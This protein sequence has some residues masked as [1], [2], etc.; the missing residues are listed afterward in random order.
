LE[1]GARS[2]TIAFLNSKGYEFHAASGPSL[3]FRRKDS[4]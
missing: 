3:I 4:V 1:Q 2:E